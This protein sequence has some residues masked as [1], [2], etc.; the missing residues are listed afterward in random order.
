MA[1]ISEDGGFKLVVG[2]LK[3]KR[4]HCK[5]SLRR[6]SRIAGVSVPTIERLED[7]DFE[8]ARL[9]D[10]LQVARA[11]K[12]HLGV[13]FVPMR[14]KPPRENSAI[15]TAFKQVLRSR[16]ALVFVKSQP[17]KKFAQIL[18]TVIGDKKR[19]WLFV[20]CENPQRNARFAA[21]TANPGGWPIGSQWAGM[22]V[23]TRCAMN[24]MSKR[25]LRRYSKELL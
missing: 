11:L 4:M 20:V 1:A 5:M 23:E 8:S 15:L 13:A 14:E 2:L 21:V 3:A 12:C 17:D 18:W 6:L 7:E 16:A 22:D 19:N 25:L 9:K 24:R 10:L